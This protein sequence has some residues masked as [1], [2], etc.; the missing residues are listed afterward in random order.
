MRANAWVSKALEESN[1]ILAFPPA[2]TGWDGIGWSVV[3]LPEGRAVSMCA[4]RGSNHLEQLQEWIKAHSENWPIVKY[5]AAWGN[6]TEIHHEMYRMKNGPITVVA[7]GALW[8]IERKG[9]MLPPPMT[10]AKAKASSA[11]MSMIREFSEEMAGGA[12][13]YYLEHLQLLS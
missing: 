6:A 8:A 2:R 5:Y 7:G 13:R 10:V 4:L 9:V 3:V 11:T 12:A 1:D